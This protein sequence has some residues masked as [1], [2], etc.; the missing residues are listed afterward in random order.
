MYTITIVVFY[1]G[2]IDGLVAD[3]SISIANALVIPQPYT[4]PSV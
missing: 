2:Y 3:C 1:Y 4:K